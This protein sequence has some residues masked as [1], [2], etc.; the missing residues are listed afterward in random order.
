MRAQPTMTPA[1]ELRRIAEQLLDLA[2]TLPTPTPE[3]AK[4]QER[5]LNQGFVT[6]EGQAEWE[7]LIRAAKHDDEMWHQR[8]AAQRKRLADELG[9]KLVT[10]EQP[11]G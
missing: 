5:W 3:Q 8:R 4:M 1:E 7:A 6:L 2:E 10:S 9:D 11:E